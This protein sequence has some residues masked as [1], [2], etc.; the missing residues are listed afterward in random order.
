MWDVDEYDDLDEELA[1]DTLAYKRQNRKP[2]K[3]KKG[4]KHECRTTTNKGRPKIKWDDKLL[5]EYQHP[6]FRVRDHGRPERSSSD[7]KS[8]GGKPAPRA[9]SKRTRY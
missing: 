1:L 5:E 9:T 6:I 7:N 2:K 3:Q 4:K 8:R